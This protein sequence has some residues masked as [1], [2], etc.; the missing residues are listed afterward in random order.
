MTAGERG[1]KGDH[2][3]EGQRGKTGD[4]GPS[5]LT[6]QQALVAFLFVTLALVV[7]A[8]RAETNAD[9]AEQRV[10]KFI[11]ELCASAPDTAPQSCFGGS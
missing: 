11:A 3:Q 10:D 2:G 9:Q 1:P 6:K 4:T 7:I 8:Y 5:V